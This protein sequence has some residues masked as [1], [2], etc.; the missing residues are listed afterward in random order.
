[1]STNTYLCGRNVCYFSVT[2]FWLNFYRAML[3]IRGSSHGPVSVSVCLCL[4]LT[5]TVTSWCSTKMAKRRITQTT[6]HDSPGT[7]GSREQ[8]LHCGLRKF[9][10]SKSLVYR[11]YTQ[12]DRRRFVYDTLPPIKLPTIG[13]VRTCRISSFCTVAWKLARLLLTRRIAW[14]LGDSQASCT[15]LLLAKP[16]C[17]FKYD[18]WQRSG[19]GSRD[20]CVLFVLRWIFGGGGHGQN[21]AGIAWPPA[22]AA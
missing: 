19:S 1:M 22:A 6:P 10:H 14:S 8:F 5:V 18:E 9:R 11:W 20:C 7:P 13:L 4:C 17:M 16:D 3:C 15:L 21:G 12:L 2:M